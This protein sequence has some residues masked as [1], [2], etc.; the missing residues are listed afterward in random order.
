MAVTEHRVPPPVSPGSDRKAS[1]DG[2]TARSCHTR[3]IIRSQ[4]RCPRVTLG[5]WRCGRLLTRPKL[6]RPLTSNCLLHKGIE[7]FLF[8]ICKHVG[9]CF[10]LD[11]S[12][13]SLRRKAC[14]SPPFPIAPLH[15]RS[16]CVKATAK[17]GRS[18]P[19]PWPILRIGRRPTSTPCGGYSAV[20][21][22]WRLKTPL[23]SSA[24]CHTALSPPSLGA[25]AA[26]AQTLH[27]AT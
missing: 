4:T 18:K 20:L 11:Y 12:F 1:H 15:R 7:V 21:S 9:R 26:W 3:R 13:S 16:C 27:S 23:R 14:L 10:V 25:D 19:G 8:F 5:C 22:W 6:P 17:A 2:Y 24:A